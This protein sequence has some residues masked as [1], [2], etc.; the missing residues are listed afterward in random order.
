MTQDIKGTANIKGTA[1]IKGS[2]NHVL[3]IMVLLDKT[4]DI[5]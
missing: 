3:C 2:D 1:H 4:Y 5:I